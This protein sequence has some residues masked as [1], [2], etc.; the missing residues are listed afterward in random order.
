[1]CKRIFLSF[2]LFLPVVLLTG[3]MG[4]NEQFIQGTWMYDDPHLRI[5]TGESENITEW[6]FDRDTFEYKS[7]CF[8]NNQHLVGRYEVIE[9]QGEILTLHLSHIRGDAVFGRIEIQVVVNFEED[10][11]N[12]QGTGPYVRIITVP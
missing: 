1:M 12:I 3:C 5:T 2:A 8:N 6:T 10:T 11:L 7:C 9:S 4:S